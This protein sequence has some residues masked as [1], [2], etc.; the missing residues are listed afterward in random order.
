MEE[1]F[2]LVPFDEESKILINHIERNFQV[3]K[4][5]PVY[6]MNAT[7]AHEILTYDAKKLYL[8]KRVVFSENNDVLSLGYIQF[9]DN[10]NVLR[11]EITNNN[12]YWDALLNQAHFLTNYMS[13]K[14]LLFSRLVSSQYNRFYML[15]Y[16]IT[17]K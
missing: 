7:A 3:E 6:F 1:K 5:E 14:N 12:V 9:Y 15:G 4:V 2:T 16:R 10:G 8:A 17:L 13:L 11:F